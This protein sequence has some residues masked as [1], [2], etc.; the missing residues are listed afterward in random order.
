MG[1]W[2]GFVLLTFVVFCVEIFALVVFVLCSVCPMLPISIECPLSIVP[3]VFF[4]VYIRL[5]VSSLFLSSLSRCLPLKMCV[6]FYP[7][8]FANSAECNFIMFI[9]DILRINKITLVV[10]FNIWGVLDTIF[11]NKVCQWLVAGRWF[12]LGTP[13]SS[14]NKMDR[15]NIAE[16]LMKVAL[17]TITLTLTRSSL[18]QLN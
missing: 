6:L 17:N 13:V 9:D 8:H 16:I 5:F 18:H 10:H 3:S 12:S 15:H 2:W 7:F 14:T 11:C 4:N 1:F